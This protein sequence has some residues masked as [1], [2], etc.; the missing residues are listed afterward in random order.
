MKFKTTSFK[1][2]KIIFVSEIILMSVAVM[3]V[4]LLLF[5]PS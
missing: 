2:A 4:F 5:E 1:G 3:L